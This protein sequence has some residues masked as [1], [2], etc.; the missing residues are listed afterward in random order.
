VTIPVSRLSD[1]SVVAGAGSALRGASRTPEEGAG[2][3]G[4]EQFVDLSRNF[5][6]VS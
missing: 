1:R 2:E 4:F 6:K 5:I 3:R